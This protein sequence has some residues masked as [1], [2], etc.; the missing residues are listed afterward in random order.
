ML[1]PTSPLNSGGREIPGQ[2]AILTGLAGLATAVQRACC[3]ASERYQRPSYPGAISPSGI[4]SD[5][6]VGAPTPRA[7][8]V[9]SRLGGG[10]L[11]VE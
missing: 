5:G 9:Q 7:E 4:L 2:R 1:G 11:H 6:L 8:A 10:V 3:A